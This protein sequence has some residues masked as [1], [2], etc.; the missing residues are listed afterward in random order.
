MELLT[1]LY[2]FTV[3]FGLGYSTKKLLK[4]DKFR[5]K[6]EEIIFLIGLGLSSFVLLCIP[7][8]LIHG[9]FWYVFLIISIIIPIYSLGE[10]IKQNKLKLNFSNIGYKNYLIVG[11][12]TLVFFVVYITGAFSY[13]YLEDDD[14]WGHAIAAKYVSIEHTYFQPEHMPIHYLEPYPPF[15]STLMGVLHQVNPESIQW[16]LKFFNVLLITLGLPFAYIWLRKF[17][18]S[19]KIALTGTFLLAVLPCFMNHFIWAQTLAMVLWFPALYSIERMKEEKNKKWLIIAILTISTILITQPSVA[20]V[21]GIFYTTYFFVEFM[22]QLLKQDSKFNIIKVFKNKEIKYLFLGGLLGL[23][24]ALSIYWIPE[25]NFRGFDGVLGAMGAKISFFEGGTTEDTSGGIVY[26]LQDFA[27]APEVSKMDQ[28]T[29]L[30]PVIFVL[31]LFS[32]FMLLYYRKKLITSHNKYLLISLL[33]V[34]IGFLGVEGN[35]LPYKLMPHR[36]WVFFAIPVVVLVAWG[37]ILIYNSTKKDKAI[38]YT[39][40][41]LIFVGILFTSAY[42]KYVVETSQWPPGVGWVSNEQ[43]QG[44]IGLKELSPNTKVFPLC[45]HIKKKSVIG[46][47]KM[48]YPWI[49]EIK[50]YQKL[51]LNDTINNNYKFLKKHNYEYL[52]LDGSCVKDFGLNQSN[53]KLQ[54]IFSSGKFRVEEKFSNK[55]FFLFKIL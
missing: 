36:F 28:A 4:L 5:D 25:I 11:L 38:A 31:L 17:T 13:P 39:I 29:G 46:M 52:I 34:I 37:I 14:S 41:S 21:F 33:W 9:L 32:V 47:D 49:K 22:I 6:I 10:N 8:S 54:E 35:A 16:V 20:A 18:R 55:G 15:Y 19:D 40:L 1:I 7:L 24:L 12:I 50:N 2:F 27:I 43:I 45:G 26:G 23:S 53:S 42:P 44:Y 51:A 48:D 30:G 3:I